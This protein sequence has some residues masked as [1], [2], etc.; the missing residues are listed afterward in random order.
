MD[1]SDLCVLPLA[2]SVAAMNPPRG[3]SG[4]IHEMNSNKGK[5]VCL[6]PSHFSH[7]SENSMISLKMLSKK[8]ETG[9]TEDG[10][11]SRMAEKA[12]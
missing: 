2:N 8:T 10:V 9:P 7:L 6:G 5:F 4:C 11:R 12:L 1:C 3:V